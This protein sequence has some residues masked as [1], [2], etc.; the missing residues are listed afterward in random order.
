MTELPESLERPRHLDLERRRLEVWVRRAGILALLAI[1]AIALA[2][3]FGQTGS[4]VT[5]AGT[6]ATLRLDAPRAL[7]SGLMY[8]ARFEIEADRTI[9]RPVLVLQDGWFDGMTVNSLEPAPVDETERNGYV[10]L[11]FGALDAGD[12][13]T[14]YIQL[15]ANPTTFGR[16]S[17]TVILE[18][19]GEAIAQID[20]TIT[21]F[22]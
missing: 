16:R 6:A 20:R 7:R 12:S 13:L 9:E 15:Q 5:A 19:G 8:Q 21:V 10:A 11:G 22:P 14:V 18:D 4:T 3:I 1:L 2:G 17:Q